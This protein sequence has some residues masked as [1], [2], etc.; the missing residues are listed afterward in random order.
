MFGCPW[1]DD[2]S[3]RAPGTANL[4]ER[5]QAPA[6]SVS[7]GTMHLAKGLESKAVA[8]MACD[9]GV[10][11]LQ[12]RM[13]AVARRTTPTIRAH[14]HRAGETVLSLIATV[15]RIATGESVRTT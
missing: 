2:A 1:V 7:I 13:E 15:G 8:E 4:S 6:V 11:P 9:D 5:D 14:G 3:R 10:L 12:S